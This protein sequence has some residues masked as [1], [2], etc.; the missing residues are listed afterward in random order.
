MLHSQNKTKQVG[1]TIL[2]RPVLVGI[3]ASYLDA[4]NNGVV[5]TISSWQS[6]EEAERHKSYDSTIQVYKAS[7]DRSKLPEEAAL[8]GAHEAPMRNSWDAFNAGGVGASRR[9]FCT[10]LPKSFED[11]K[12]TAFMDA[13]LQCS[14]AIKSM[15]KRLRAAC[16]SNDA[17]SSQGS[18]CSII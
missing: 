4:L 7:F 15:V 14:I 1:S 12:R 17:S 2:T 9:R 5:L 16:H 10:S 8:R 3:T 18:P 13:D 6:I 11:Y